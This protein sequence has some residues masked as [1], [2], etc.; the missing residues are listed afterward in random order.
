MSCKPASQRKKNLAL[1]ASLLASFMLGIDPLSSSCAL[2]HYCFA[3]SLFIYLFIYNSYYC[4]RKR[5]ERAVYSPFDM[6]FQSYLITNLLNV[7][8]KFNFSIFVVHIAVERV[9]RRQSSGIRTGTKQQ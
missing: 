7:Y 3:H 8:S 2:F 6:D 5:R 4:T 1:E 9:D